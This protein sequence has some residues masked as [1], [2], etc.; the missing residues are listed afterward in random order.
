ML[1]YVGEIKKILK[2]CPLNLWIDNFKGICA[3]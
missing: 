2:L 3:K 1:R